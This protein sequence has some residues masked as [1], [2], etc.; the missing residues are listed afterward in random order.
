VINSYD[1][2]DGLFLTTLIVA[3]QYVTV[4]SNCVSL[5]DIVDAARDHV[6][7]KDGTGVLIISCVRLSGDDYD[8]L[9]ELNC[10]NIVL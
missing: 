2:F 3:M 6:Q 10:A 8:H 7:A 1:L 4:I 9:I 5:A